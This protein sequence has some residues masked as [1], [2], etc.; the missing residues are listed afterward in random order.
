MKIHPLAQISATALAIL[1]AS[2]GAAAGGYEFPGDGARA[3]GRGGAFA[4]RAD[5]PMAVVVNP[6][7]LAAMPG[8]QIWASAHLSSAKDCF[9]RNQPGVAADGRT[10]TAPRWPAGWGRDASGDRI[11]YTEVCN[12]KSRRLTAIPSLGITW[13]VSRRV[14]MGFAIIPPNSQLGQRWGSNPYTV[15]TANGSERVYRGYVDAPAGASGAGSNPL[16]PLDNG[17]S[18]LPSSTRF[19]LVERTVIAAYPTLAVG[20]KPFRWMQIGAALGWGVAD[21]RFVTNI[22]NLVPG[23]DPNVLEGQVVVEG[24]DYFAPRLVASV[25]FIPLHIMPYYRRNYSLRERDFPVALQCYR[26]TISLP[27]YPDLEDEQVQRVITT[28][29]ELGSRFYKSR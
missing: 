12:D 21:V 3:I 18:L 7:G 15:T 13:R 16:V 26:E 11:A 8:T 2:S 27:I 4:A 19:Q 20:A 29:K 17:Q 10:E 22:R 9:T 5:D 25:H 23:E 24:R 28:I 14:G 1:G 6:A